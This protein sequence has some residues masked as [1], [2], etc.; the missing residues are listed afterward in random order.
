LLSLENAKNL[1]KEM[2]FNSLEELKKDLEKNPLDIGIFTTPR[3][4]HD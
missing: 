1:L 4:E 3:K 2:N